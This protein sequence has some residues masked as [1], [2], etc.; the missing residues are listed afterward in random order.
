MDNSIV[1]IIVI[2]LS[3]SSPGLLQHLLLNQCSIKKLDDVIISKDSALEQEPE[4]SRHEN[5]SLLTARQIIVFFH[6][7]C[8]SL[9]PWFYHVYLHFGTTRSEQLVLQTE[10][11]RR[12]KIAF[13]TIQSS[14]LSDDSHLTSYRTFCFLFS[15]WKRTDQQLCPCTIFRR[16]SAPE[17]TVFEVE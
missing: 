2:M 3:Y 12:K 9:W 11:I 17:N 16:N 6:P 10:S 14:S 15:P 1:I 13:R 4:K 5:K 7:S 8:G